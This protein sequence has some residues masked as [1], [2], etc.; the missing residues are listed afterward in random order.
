ML[1]HNLYKQISYK[2]NRLP[3]FVYFFVGS[4]ISSSIIIIGVGIKNKMLK[5]K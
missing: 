5:N 4:L 1:L 2:L 3:F